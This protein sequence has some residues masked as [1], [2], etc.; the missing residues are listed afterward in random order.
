[1]NVGALTLSV[2]L[3]HDSMAPDAMSVG[4]RST[5]LTTHTAG[6][7]RATPRGTQLPGEYHESFWANNLCERQDADL[8]EAIKI[9]N[10]WME[11][12]SEFLA[13]FL[14][15]GGTVEYYVT[16]SASDRMAFEL[17]PNMLVQCAKFGLQVSVEV[18]PT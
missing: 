15:A 8:G 6:A 17:N 14:L 9:A 13:A 5:P 10:E 11:Q 12:R 18:F 3:R 1:M 7:A 4:M 2:R 16:I